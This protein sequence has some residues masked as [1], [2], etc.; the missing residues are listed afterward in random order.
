MNVAA[1]QATVYVVVLAVFVAALCAVAAIIDLSIVDRNAG[2]L[3]LALQVLAPPLGAWAVVLFLGFQLRRD[4]ESAARHRLAIASAWA[5]AGA[6][7]IVWVLV[8]AGAS[9]TSTSKFGL[10]ILGLVLV[11]P[12]VLIFGLAATLACLAALRMQRKVQAIRESVWG[13]WTQDS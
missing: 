11:V 4:A 7:A 12:G 3:G 8:L 9:L 2:T 13:N 1:R 6:A 10:E 5:V